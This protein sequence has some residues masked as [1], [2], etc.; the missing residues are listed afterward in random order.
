MYS[1]AKDNIYVVYIHKQYKKTIYDNLRK[2]TSSGRYNFLPLQ[3]LETATEFTEID[4]H[5]VQ[6]YHA[7]NM[8]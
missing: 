7:K 4:T 5:E 2:N 6:N 1:R 3:I 8:S